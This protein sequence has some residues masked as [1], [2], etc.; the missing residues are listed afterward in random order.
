R[1]PAKERRHRLQAAASGRAPLRARSRDQPRG[2]RRRRHR[3]SGAVRRD[4][5][6]SRARPGRVDARAHERTPRCDPVRT[7][8]NASRT[9]EAGVIS[10]GV[11]A[12][13]VG[14]LALVPKQ[15]PAR[16]PTAVVRRDTLTQALVETGTI[17]AQRLMVYSSTIQGAQ[18]KIVDIVPEGTSVKPGDRLVRF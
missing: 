11:L 16:W 2:G 8:M 9:R 14:V 7:M 12:A 17:G 5:R 18:A 15:A 6:G 13:L 1:H 3:L 4:Q 10:V